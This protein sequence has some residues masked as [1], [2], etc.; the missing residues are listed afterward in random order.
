MEGSY[1]KRS[2]RLV[3]KHCKEVTL[4]SLDVARS[5]KEVVEELVS[6]KKLLVDERRGCGKLMKLGLA[7]LAFP[8][9]VI[10]NITG[11]MLLTLGYCMNKAGRSSNLRDMLKAI[12]ELRHFLASPCT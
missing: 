8:E 6:V 4:V 1:N 9:P 12:R 5:V 7:C 3:D 11:S 2:L 10:S